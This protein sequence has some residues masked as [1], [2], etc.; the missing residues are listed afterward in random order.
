MSLARAQAAQGAIVKASAIAQAPALAIESQQRHEE[1]VG[2][3]ARFV[4]RRFGDAPDAGRGLISGLPGAEQ[5]AACP[6][7]RSPARPA[8]RRRRRGGAAVAR[9]GIHRRA[10]RN[11]KRWPCRL[12]AAGSQAPPRQWRWL[13]APSARPCS[14]RVGSWPARAMPAFAQGSSGSHRRLSALRRPAR[15]RRKQQSRESR[16]SGDPARSLRDV[17]GRR[18]SGTT[19]PDRD[20]SRADL[21]GPRVALLTTHPAALRAQ[22]LGRVHE[23]QC[24]KNQCGRKAGGPTGPRQPRAWQAAGLQERMQRGALRPASCRRHVLRASA[25]L[26]ERLW[27]V[28]RPR[29]H[30][31]CGAALRGPGSHLTSENYQAL[32]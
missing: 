26:A 15:A 6:C 8:A 18:V 1:N 20:S 19:I 10:A 21:I 17:G 9:A 22:R 7:R 4:G 31:G 29:A 13:P 24:G 3:H 5:Q 11:R 28:H 25:I 2:L 23:N 14:S 16:A 30:A 12:P 27:H 32:P